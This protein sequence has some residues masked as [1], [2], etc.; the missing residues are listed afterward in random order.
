MLFRRKIMDAQSAINTLSDELGAVD[1][2]NI[3]ELTY[4]FVFSAGVD[5]GAVQPETAHEKAYTGTWSPE[6]S[7]VSFGNNVVKH[8]MITGITQAR[9]VRISTGLTN[10][11]VTI[12]AMGR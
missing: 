6:G 3:N 2:A 10:G 8:T 12:W 1:L 7:P 4:Y 11:T 5:A 9:R